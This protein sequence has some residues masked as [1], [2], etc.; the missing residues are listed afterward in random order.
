MKTT[1]ERFN[2]LLANWPA[3]A[4]E[5]PTHQG[6][7]EAKCQKLMDVHGGKS[8]PL[9]V[10]RLIAE[11]LCE[12]VRGGYFDESQAADGSYVYTPTTKKQLPRENH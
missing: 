10:A 8:T 9:W 12:L 4:D 7:D 1:D 5:P 11:V 6:V 3:E 2:E